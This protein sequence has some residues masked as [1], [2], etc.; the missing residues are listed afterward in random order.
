MSPQQFPFGPVPT[1]RVSIRRRF[2]RRVDIA[3]GYDILA[4]RARLGRF[5]RGHTFPL[6]DGSR[7]EVLRSSPLLH[8][9]WTVRLNGHSLPGS[10]GT[11]S[12]ARAIGRRVGL[13]LVLLA[14]AHWLTWFGISGVCAD[15]WLASNPHAKWLA[16][17]PGTALAVLGA[18][19]F[20][21]GGSVALGL[22][23]GLLLADGAGAWIPWPRDPEGPLVASA[24]ARVLCLASLSLGWLAIQRARGDVI[25]RA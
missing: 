9:G 1:Q 5:R 21:G 8:G 18:I 13:L 2:G 15:S 17:I 10:V 16:A 19:V 4:S 3:F 20:F 25:G 14:V 11:H 12:H 22:A 24:A 7:L 6:S 23:I